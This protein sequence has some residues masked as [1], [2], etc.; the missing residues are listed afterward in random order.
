M[1]QVRG[2][3]LLRHPSVWTLF[4]LTTTYVELLA[5]AGAIGNRWTALCV[6]CVPVQLCY[7]TRVFIG[8]FLLRLLYFTHSPF[9]MKVLSDLS[10]Q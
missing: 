2:Q 4:R 5:P 9:G 1:L 10:Q 6:T 7:S 8:I 3:W